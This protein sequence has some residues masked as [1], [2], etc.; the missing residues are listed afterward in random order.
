MQKSAS[1]KERVLRGN[2]LKTRDN[3]IRE[4]MEAHCIRGKF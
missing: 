4:S 1:P 2:N 3:R